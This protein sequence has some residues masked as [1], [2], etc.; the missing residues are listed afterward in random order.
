MGWAALII[1]ENGDV[2]LHPTS[3]PT[4][5]WPSAAPTIGAHLGSQFGAVQ[6]P[7][8]P[9]P[10]DLPHTSDY[11]IRAAKLYFGIVIYFDYS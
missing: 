1:I 11:V 9:D 2:G 10:P 8:M 4:A 6:A 7:V 3:P 5:P